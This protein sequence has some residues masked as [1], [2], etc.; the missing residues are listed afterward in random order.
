MWTIY[1]PD[2]MEQAAVNLIDV[3]HAIM[4]FAWKSSA[5]QSKMELCNTLDIVSKIS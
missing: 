3:I 5:Q 2:T 4:T 1:G